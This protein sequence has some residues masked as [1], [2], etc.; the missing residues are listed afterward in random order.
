MLIS[1][2]AHP[3]RG[4]RRCDRWTHT[5][6]PQAHSTI[7]AHVHAHHDHDGTR[8]ARWPRQRRAATWPMARRITR[9][10]TSPR[11]KSPHSPHAHT[12][13]QTQGCTHTH[14]HAGTHV[15]TNAHGRTIEMAQ[16]EAD[17]RAHAARG[18]AASRWRPQRACIRRAPSRGRMAS[19]AR[20]IPRL[21]RLLAGRTRA[22]PAGRRPRACRRVRGRA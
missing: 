20:W 14:T 16:A 13:T 17:G 6:P 3:A 2:T 4:L 7:H 1:L 19:P 10:P 21:G 18:L 8:H 11:V 9:C 12:H 5:P 15:P 22:S